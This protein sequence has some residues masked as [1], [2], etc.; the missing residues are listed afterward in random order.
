MDSA[1]WGQTGPKEERLDMGA[2]ARTFLKFAVAVAL[3]V[4]AVGFGSKR[5]GGY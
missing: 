1:A 3:A 2:Q 4:A 5:M